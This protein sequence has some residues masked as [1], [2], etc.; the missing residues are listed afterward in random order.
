LDEILELHKRD[1]VEAEPDDFVT[2]R[3]DDAE[4]QGLILFYINVGQMPTQKAESLTQRWKE[5]TERAFRKLPE[6]YK[7]IW[8]PTRESKTRVEFLQLP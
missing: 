5:K 3:N 7:I 4:L 1:E 6:R 8:I 2:S